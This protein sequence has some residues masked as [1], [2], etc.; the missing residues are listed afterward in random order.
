LCGARRGIWS[1]HLS[2]SCSPP[3]RD[4]VGV[5]GICSADPKNIHEVPKMVDCNVR[6]PEDK[7]TKPKAKAQNPRSYERVQEALA[8]APQFEQGSLCSL[9]LGKDR[10]HLAR[11]LEQGLPPPAS[12]DQVGQLWRT[13]LPIHPPWRH[14][15]PPTTRVYTHARVHVLCMCM[16]MCTHA[17]ACARTHVRVHVPC[18]CTR[19][20]VHVQVTRELT[21]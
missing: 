6:L 8:D 10:Q 7:H 2:P 9:S 14:I 15:L 3:H 12:H 5:F 13:P 21:G 20:H 17:C 11:N 1:L 4:A 16:C 18:A 19:T